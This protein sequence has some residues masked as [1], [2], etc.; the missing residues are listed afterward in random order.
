MSGKCR[1]C[2]YAVWDTTASGKL[3]PSGRGNCTYEV[4]VPLLPMWADSLAHGFAHGVN[5]RPTIWR[6]EDRPCDVYLA[7]GAAS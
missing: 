1:T 2:A 4:P 5:K 7:E 6:N 3:H